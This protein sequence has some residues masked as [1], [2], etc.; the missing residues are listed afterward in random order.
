MRGYTDVV[1]VETKGGVPEAFEWRGRRYRVGAVLER[2]RE[3]TPWWRLTDYAGPQ[4]LERTLWR[5]EA[6]PGRL[7]AT[8]VFELAQWRERWSL[9]R[10]SD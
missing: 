5:V 10:L 2:W 8:G 3:S 6:S 7:P 1:E 4:D 9:E